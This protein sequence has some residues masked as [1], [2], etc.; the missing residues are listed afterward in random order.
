MLCLERIDTMKGQIIKIHYDPQETGPAE[1][2]SGRI[3]RIVDTPV[4]GD[5][6]RNT[7]ARLD[8]DPSKS[9]EIPEIKEVLYSPYPQRSRLEFQEE[10]EL[11]M[12]L[13]IFRLLGAEG[14][15]VIMPTKGKPGTLVISHEEHIDP[16]ALANSIGVPQSEP[17]PDEDESVDG[18]TDAS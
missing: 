11:I 14:Q 13:D 18:D 16:V 4:F 2:L 8:C 3:V 12:L 7:I 17:E 6:S 5:L 1:I 9:T 10:V 15:A